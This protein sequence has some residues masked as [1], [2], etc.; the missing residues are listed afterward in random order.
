[1]NK[2]WEKEIP[3]NYHTTHKNTKMGIVKYE[4]I[5]KQM[6][7]DARKNGRSRPW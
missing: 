7:I 3:G 1:M 4:K 2:E 5:D 6:S